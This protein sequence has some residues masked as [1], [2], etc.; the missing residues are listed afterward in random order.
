MP[1]CLTS[2]E[3]QHGRGGCDDDPR[4]RPRPVEDIR[5]ARV[6]RLDGVVDERGLRQ[7]QRRHDRDRHDS[8]HT[9]HDPR[10][11]ARRHGLRERIETIEDRYPLTKAADAYRDLAAG[12]LRGRA[13]CI[14]AA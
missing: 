5:E 9:G 3:P 13:V 10:A 6:Q 4:E 14:P 7:H 8:R 1:G 12:K 11:A 2:G